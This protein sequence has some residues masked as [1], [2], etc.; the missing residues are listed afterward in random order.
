MSSQKE[1]RV[2]KRSWTDPKTQRD[3]K[4]SKINLTKSKERQRG[5]TETKRRPIHVARFPF[6]AQT[7]FS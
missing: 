2:A 5:A 1:L 4:S 7:G 3:A 6:L